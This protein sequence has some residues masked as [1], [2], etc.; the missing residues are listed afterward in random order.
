MRCVQTSTNAKLPDLTIQA[1][2]MCRVLE[3]S[4]PATSVDNAGS[5]FHLVR[6][7]QCEYMLIS[8]KNHKRQKMAA[9]GECIGLKDDKYSPL[10]DKN[11]AYLSMLVVAQRWQRY[12]IV[13][14]GDNPKSKK[15]NHSS[16]ATKKEQ[17]LA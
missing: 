2:A 7:A 4:S 16:D 17:V 6:C 10:D 12:T 8:I 14:L 11:N 5:Q 13:L 1:K 9:R 3:F 15:T